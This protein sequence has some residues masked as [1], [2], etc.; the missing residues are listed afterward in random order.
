MPV[1]VS[2][3][4]EDCALSNREKETPTMGFERKKEQARKRATAVRESAI[5]A[6]RRRERTLT[7][8]VKIV[9]SSILEKGA[10]TEAPSTQGGL[11]QVVLSYL[12]K[13]GGFLVTEEQ[14]VDKISK[15]R[16]SEDV[17]EVQIARVNGLHEQWGL[18][19]KFISKSIY[20][21]RFEDGAVFEQSLLSYGGYVSRIYYVVERNEFR[22][23]AQHNFRK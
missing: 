14:L 20:A 18:D 17:M 3:I 11:E 9:G 13:R 8:G 12:L 19:R 5:I 22:A 21:H 10:E 6:K 15:K 2:Y 16:D 7:P 1:T 23:F 4:Q